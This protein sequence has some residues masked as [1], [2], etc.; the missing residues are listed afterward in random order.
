MG[1]EPDETLVDQVI[2]GAKELEA[3][4]VQMITTS[5]GFLAACSSKSSRRP[6]RCRC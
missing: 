6:C 1:A 2:A 5:C 4:G 3:G